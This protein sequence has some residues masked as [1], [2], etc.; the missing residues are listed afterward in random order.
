MHGTGDLDF[1]G[2]C[3]HDDPLYGI[4]LRTGDPAADDWSSDLV[5]D[6]DHIVEW[7]RSESGMRFRVAPA[8]LTFHGVSDLRIDIDWGMR[9]WQVAPAPPTVD[10]IERERVQTEM[11]RVYLDGAYY[12]WR[13]ALSS[14]V[15]ASI[16]FAALGFDLALR[17][18][19][20][21][22]DEQRFPAALRWSGT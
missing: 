17:R 10:R 13:I 19:P 11:Q 12:T 9:G 8:T 15:G 6:I 3:C 7:V 5:L 14:P 18:E 4:A 1:D 16:S 2:F 20:L 22:V 21:L